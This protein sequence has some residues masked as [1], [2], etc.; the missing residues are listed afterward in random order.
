MKNFLIY[1][2]L[3]LFVIVGFGCEDCEDP[4][5]PECDNYAPCYGQ[6]PVTA[7]FEMYDLFPTTSLNRWLEEFNMSQVPMPDDT[8]VN[9]SIYF[10]AP[11][12]YTKYT[13]IVG[14]ETINERGFSRSHFPRGVDIPIQLIVEGE[15]SP[16]FPTDDGIDTL[17][18]NIFIKEMN[19]LDS[20]IINS[21]LSVGKFEGAYESNPSDIFTIEIDA[22]YFNNDKGEYWYEPRIYNLPPSICEVLICDR[23]DPYIRNHLAFTTQG[24]TNLEDCGR[25]AGIITA[26]S[27]SIDIRYKDLL[28]NEKFYHFRGRRV[29]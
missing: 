18:K 14:S 22:F 13:W 16:C 11:E 5:N 7:S 24:G 9:H 27:D 12:G 25:P 8:A 1:S 3:S 20:N 26:T 29:N 2:L 23:S 17:Q 19:P 21:L 15:V 28:D 6:S 10:E 4:T